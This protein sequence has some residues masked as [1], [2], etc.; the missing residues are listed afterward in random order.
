MAE[1]SEEVSKLLVSGAKSYA[2][3]EYEEAVNHYGEACQVYSSDNEGKESPEL[4]FLYGKAL[5]QVAVSKNGIFGG[6]PDEAAALATEEEDDD[7]EEEN[8]KEIE[9]K[10]QEETANDDDKEEDKDEEEKEE[11]Q[12]DFEIAWEIL[13]LAR[14]LYEQSLPETPLDKIPEDAENSKDPIV[15]TKIKLSDIH[16]L[17]GEISLETENFKQASEDFQSLLKIREE[18]FPFESNL[19]SEAHYKLSLALEFNFADEE[20][21]K[22]AIEHLKKAIESIKLKQKDQKDED[23]DIDLI[24]ELDSRLED[25]QKDPNE[26]FDEQK[27]DIIK[28]ILGEVTSSDKQTPRPSTSAQ[29][30]ND[31]TSIVKKRKAK[32]PNDSAKKTKQ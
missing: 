11:E 21:K 2:A 19:I 10:Q 17:L 12:S 13:D 32:Q 3:K 26:A 18:L 9:A 24:K 31:L 5:F 29:P 27:N 23:K 20:S 25:L 28:G 8:Q 22:K 16:D 1:Y 6:N 15:V 30:V 14:S 4:L 7:E